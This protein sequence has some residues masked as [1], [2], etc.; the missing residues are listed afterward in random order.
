DDGMPETRRR[1]LQRELAEMELA[2]PDVEAVLSLFGAHRLLTVERG[3]STRGPT[4]EVAHEALLREWG[5]LR[6]WIDS[7]LE[8]VRAQRRLVAST[9][10]WESA[11]QERSVLLV[12]AKLEQ[13]EASLA[14]ST[15]ALTTSE[16]SYLDASVARREVE[17]GRDRASK[18]RE[19][20]LQRRSRDRLR[21]LVAIFAIATIVASGLS[22][23]ALN[24]QGIA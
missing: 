11:G 8:G 10:D 5:R 16:R 7:A 14:T 1:V 12:G 13:M 19:A 24:Q 22:L 2:A 3:P 18:A 17:L 4:V 9:R 23:F 15:V 20:A 6:G 21:A